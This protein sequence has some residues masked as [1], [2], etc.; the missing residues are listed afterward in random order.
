ML[1][2]LFIDIETYSSVDLK[3]CGAYRYSESPDFD[4]MMAAYALDDEPVQIALGMDRV[5]EIPGLW[6]PSIIKVAHNAAFERICFSRIMPDDGYNPEPALFM[7][8]RDFLD[9]QALAGEKGY[10]QKL[11]YLAPALGVQEKDSAGIHLINFFCKPDRN[12]KRRRPED[13]PEKWQQFIR[14]CMQDVETLRD[15]RRA[16]G[17]WPTEME[18]EIWISDQLIN[19]AGIPVDLDMVRKAVDVASY[20]A[21]EQDLQFVELTGVKNPNSG[22]QIH[23]WLQSQAVILPNLQSDTIDDYLLT[24]DN[25]SSTV[26]EAL[27]L[28]QELALVASKKFTAALQRTSADGRLRGAFHFFGAHTGRWAGRGV[29]LQN[30]PR[31]SL[32][33]KTDTDA[34]IDAKIQNAVDTLMTDGSADAFTLKALV[35]SMFTGPF[36]VV[37]YSAIEARVV[38]WLAGEEWALQ[39]FRDGRDIYVETAERMGGLSRQEGKVAVLALGYGGGI[40]ALRIMGAEGNDAK[41][42]FLVDQWRAANP[43][44]KNYWRELEEAF[45]YGDRAVGDHIYVTKD[46]ADRLV[47]LPSGRAVAY[48]G[49]KGKMSPTPWGEMRMKINYQSPQMAGRRIWTWGGT[50]TENIT[51][52]VARDVLAEAIVRLHAKGHEIVGHVHDEVLVLGTPS[53]EEITEIMVDP[54]AWSAGLPINAEGFQCPRYR[55]G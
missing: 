53:I 3:K 30:L 41:L 21:F 20:N 27:E 45:R 51:Q 17:E 6:D 15:V 42:Q 37:D 31:Q 7:D 39:A 18:R 44:I 24:N 9:T 48:H 11:E 25:V 46:G 10:P 35:R 50:L 12:G 49:L 4:I 29:Q 19:D 13:H 34:E 8:P 14:Y 43:Q 16:L 23:K 40:N 33:A 1:H 22:P 32:A 2:E 36:T 28:K 52:A 54:P 38:S 5:F 47:Q 26:R 55:K